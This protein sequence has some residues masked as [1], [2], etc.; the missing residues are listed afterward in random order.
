MATNAGWALLS[1]LMRQRARKSRGFLRAERYVVAGVFFVLA[2][3]TLAT[4][5]TSG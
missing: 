4:G 1:S 3:A 5:L 2:A